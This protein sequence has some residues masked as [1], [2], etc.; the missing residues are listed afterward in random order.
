MAYDNS[1]A[2]PDNLPEKILHYINGEFVESLDGDEFEVLDP[3]TDETYITAASGKSADIDRA[4]A[5]AKDAF[6]NGPWARALPRERSR[7]LHKIAD[8]VESRAATLAE[9]TSPF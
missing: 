9:A 7:V 4:V 2:K 6:D 1:A 8:I 5:A 3:V